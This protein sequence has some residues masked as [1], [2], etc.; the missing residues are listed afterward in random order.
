[1]KLPLPCIICDK[2]LQSV[3]TS[4]AMAEFAESDINQPN[5]ATTFISHGQYGSTLWD[6]MNSDETLEINI[7]DPC[8]VLK[9]ESVIHV[10]AH[11]RNEYT[12]RPWTEVR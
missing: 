2:P 9:M 7:C 12:T 10:T 5:D 4:K 3:F 8:L 6:P 1:M 11:R